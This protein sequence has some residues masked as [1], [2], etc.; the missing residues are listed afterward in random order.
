MQIQ[1]NLLS[2]FT[3]GLSDKQQFDG[4]NNGKGGGY[5]GGKGG[6]YNSGKGDGYNGG[7][8]PMQT[9]PPPQASSSG[10]PGMA[11]GGGAAAAA[12]SNPYDRNVS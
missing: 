2:L 10:G 8:V 3:P 4:Y 12:V 11:Y 5:N 7:G 9:Y 6:G 1:L